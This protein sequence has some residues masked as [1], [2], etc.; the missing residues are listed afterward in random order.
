MTADDSNH[1]FLERYR[2]IGEEQRE[3]LHARLMT[4]DIDEGRATS[5]KRQES[6]KSK[7]CERA[8]EPRP[9]GR[10]MSFINPSA[11]VTILETKPA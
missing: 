1:L 10:E 3:D 6:N 8:P 7:A 9:R 4:R 2:C 11:D 5:V